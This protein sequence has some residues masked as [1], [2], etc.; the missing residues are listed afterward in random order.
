MS[1]GQNNARKLI[2]W[3]NLGWGGLTKQ[4]FSD[5]LRRSKKARNN[6]I[7]RFPEKS[8]LFY[9]KRFFSSRRD[10]SISGQSLM[11]SEFLRRGKII[12]LRSKKC[13]GKSDQASWSQI[14]DPEGLP[15][16]TKSRQTYLYGVTKF[17]KT[18]WQAWAPW[19][20][21]NDLLANT[22]NYFELG[23]KLCQ[24]GWPLRFSGLSKSN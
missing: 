14:L 3:A 20:V 11:M 19:E 9:Q 2:A 4:N 5:P 10:W 8:W 23:L 21:S 18:L 6:F 1:C 24:L 7:L 12:R 13:L 16:L 22:F 15:F 17:S